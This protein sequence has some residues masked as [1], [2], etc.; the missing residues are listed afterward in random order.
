MIR[1]A[2][3]HNLVLGKNMKVFVIARGSFYQ[4]YLKCSAEVI[5]KH[6][7]ESKSGKKKKKETGKLILLINWNF[8]QE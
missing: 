2:K 6:T 5:R 3:G 8:L 4:T 7:Q 1:K